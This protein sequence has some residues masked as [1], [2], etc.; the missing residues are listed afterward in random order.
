[1]NCYDEL[2]ALTTEAQRLWFLLNGID[3]LAALELKAKRLIPRAKRRFERRANVLD[4]YEAD[5]RME[6][7]VGHIYDDEGWL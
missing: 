7:D 1:M 5:Q 4:E 6:A 2:L 3:R